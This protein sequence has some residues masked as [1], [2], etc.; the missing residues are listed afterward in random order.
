[1][2]LSSESQIDIIKR[3]SENK[4]TKKEENAL[5]L[6]L[7]RLVYSVCL[8][9]K[10]HLGCKYHD[11]DLDDLVQDCW[12]KVWNAIPSYNP[13]YAVS[14]WVHSIARNCCINRFN[15][16]KKRRH[17][18]LAFDENIFSRYETKDDTVKL[19]VDSVIALLYKIFPNQSDILSE[20]FGDIGS[21]NFDIPKKISCVKISKKL[22]LPYMKVYRFLWD[23]LYPAIDMILND[24]SGKIGCMGSHSELCIR[25]CGAFSLC[26]KISK[27][28]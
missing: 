2:N 16:E 21:C 3:V 10:N 27:D 23:K 20:I 28:K 8:G 22:N 5:V 13:D 15:Y 19:S 7:Y 1:M 24:P 18:V 6:S 25:S 9:F 17:I 26:K 14:T 11:N 12:V 4:A